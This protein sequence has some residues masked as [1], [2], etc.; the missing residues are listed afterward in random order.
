MPQQNT[1]ESQEA[2]KKQIQHEFNKWLNEPYEDVGIL[3][4]WFYEKFEKIFMMAN[5][6]TVVYRA[7]TMVDLFNK[8]KS[9]QIELLSVLQLDWMAQLWLGVHPALVDPDV[10]KFLVK[11]IFLEQF[12]DKLE[13]KKNRHLTVLGTKAYSMNQVAGNLR[14]PGKSLYL[15]TR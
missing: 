7:D 2:I 1:A 9:K 10:H 3:P 15:P 12:I 11:R 14:T 6:M 4:S 13:T 5:Q 8:I